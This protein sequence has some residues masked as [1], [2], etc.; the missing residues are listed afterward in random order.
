MKS[1][2]FTVALGVLSAF[3]MN[4]ALPAPDNDT[5]PNDFDK[6]PRF[7]RNHRSKLSRDHAARTM[8]I[9]QLLLDRYDLDDNGL[10]EGE[11]RDRLFRDAE[12]ARNE[13][14]RTL[15]KRFDLDGDGKLN[16][17]EYERLL[18][19]I[20]SQRRERMNHPQ[21]PIDPPE[22]V[23]RPM[24]P[25][26]GGPLALLTSKLILEKYD[27]DGNGSLDKNELQNLMS[28]AIK[29]FEERR[30]EILDR[31]DEDHNGTLSPQEAET[32]RRTLHEEREVE[33]VFPEHDPI[34]MYLNTHYDM[35]IIRS[36]DV[37]ARQ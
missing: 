17:A 8:L 35:D 34:D 14:M 37:P 3:D 19:H 23:Y 33:A 21:P 25:K 12:N 5:M 16:T 10:I 20:R 11:E 4:A 31:F 6:T 2:L 29:L 27:A 22:R 30:K 28:D 26:R 9:R 7:R 24:P 13:A 18:K 1:V 15:I 32:A 36:L